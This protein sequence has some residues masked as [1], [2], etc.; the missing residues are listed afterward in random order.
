M[1]TPLKM[2]LAAVLPLASL[3]WVTPPADA[4]DGY[5]SHEHR[6]SWTDTHSYRDPSTGR[7]RHSYRDP[8]T[9]LSRDSYRHPYYGRYRDHSGY[10][11]D[12]GRRR[13]YYSSWYYGKNA[14]KYNKAMNRLARQE[15]EAQ[16][17]AYRR[18]EGD[19]RD[20]RFRERL[21]EVDRRYDRKRY[22]VE[23]NLR[24]D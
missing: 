17:K 7:Y 12:W 15:R 16:A 20:P 3:L 6:R 4:H 21:A 18:Y 9:G 11:N 1:R 22:Q 8:S 10:Y 24:N 14:R 5:R 19:R 2:T 23:R 13:G